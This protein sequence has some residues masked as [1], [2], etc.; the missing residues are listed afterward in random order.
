APSGGVRSQKVVA[1]NIHQV[2]E[3]L[4]RG[5]R[6]PDADFL[7]DGEKEFRRRHARI[8]YECDLGVLRCLRQQGAHDR[9]LS[10]PHLAGELHETAGLVD[11]IEE[12]SQG[13][14]VALT[15]IEVARIRSDREWL[16][17]ESE[18]REIHESLLFDRIA[19]PQ[20][21][22]AKTCAGLVQRRVETRSVRRRVFEQ[23]E[24]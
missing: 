4:H 17:V 3:A 10:S 18:K 9:G 11:A 5:V 19:A 2:L 8:Q 13:F 7:A 16:F 1:E 15:Q 12:M 21:T 22:A 14:G 20:C 24:L 23:A 6:D